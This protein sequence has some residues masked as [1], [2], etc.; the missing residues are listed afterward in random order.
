MSDDDASAAPQEPPDLSLLQTMYFT[1]LLSVLKRDII[2]VQPGNVSTQA[3]TEQAPLVLPPTC[4][5]GAEGGGD[6]CHGWKLL[7]PSYDALGDDKLRRVYMLAALLLSAQDVQA[8]TFA[9]LS[10]VR[11]PSTAAR[12]VRSRTKLARCLHHLIGRR[13]GRWRGW[14]VFGP[15]AEVE[16]VVCGICALRELQR[17]PSETKRT[18]LSKPCIWGE[19]G[20]G[21]TWY[22]P[23]IAPWTVHFGGRGHIGL[24]V[25]S[26]RRVRKTGWE[27]KSRGT[28]C[29]P[30]I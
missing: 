20:F 12:L 18:Y 7:T 13:R 1:R 2:L 23:I 30:L 16:R 24:E 22:E 14:G 8:G 6:Q 10:V 21:Q 17:G 27:E 26:C 11:S 9:S 3:G 15:V 25:S 29:L 5:R 28:R 4:W 19:P